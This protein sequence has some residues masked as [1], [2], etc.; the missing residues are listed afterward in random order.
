M[1]DC[2]LWYDSGPSR[3]FLCSRP[4]F[5]IPVRCLNVIITKEMFCS[6]SVSPTDSPKSTHKHSPSEPNFQ[7]PLPPLSS[8]LQPQKETVTLSAVSKQSCKCSSSQGAGAATATSILTGVSSTG[9]KSKLTKS[10]AVSGDEGGGDTLTC[11]H[12]SGA[13]D[14][15]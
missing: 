10:G 5:C 9:A 4:K 11:R 2:L 15:R 6:I 8:S 14:I 3:G 1:C 13:V 7:A 12:C